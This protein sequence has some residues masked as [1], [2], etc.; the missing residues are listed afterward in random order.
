MSGKEYSRLLQRQVRRHVPPGLVPTL[1]PFLEMVNES[2]QH[3]EQD[4]DMLSR[5]MELISD[6]LKASN[7][8]LLRSNES[9][10]SFQQHGMQ[11]E[12]QKSRA[13][14]DEILNAQSQIIAPR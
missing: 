5:A 7:R 10:E 11:Y 2:Y 6:E 4:R 9:L 14:Y 12:I 8:E 3:Y 1:A 13:L